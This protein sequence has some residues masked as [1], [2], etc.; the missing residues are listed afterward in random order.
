MVFCFI[1]FCLGGSF[2]LF[3][4]T[5]GHTYRS[6]KRAFVSSFIILHLIPLRQNISLNQKLTILARPAGQ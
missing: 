4:S 6:Q 3:A 5:L 2:V 1:C